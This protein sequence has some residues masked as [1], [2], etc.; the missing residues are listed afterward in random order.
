MGEIYDSDPDED[1]HTRNTRI[2]RLTFV[3]SRGLLIGCCSPPAA[4]WTALCARRTSESSVIH[5][6]KKRKDVR[7]EAEKVLEMPPLSCHPGIVG[8]GL[9][10]HLACY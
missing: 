7:E 2:K 5:G 4:F 8:T 10:L 1:L 3:H 6:S 9:S